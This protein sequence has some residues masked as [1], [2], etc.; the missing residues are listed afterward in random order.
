MPDNHSHCLGPRVMAALT[1]LLC[2][3]SIEQARSACEAAAWG[4]TYSRN[5]C[6]WLVRDGAL[7]ALANFMRSCSSNK[8]QSSILSAIL[9]ILANILSHSE[10][11]LHIEPKELAGLV[12]IVTD[13][14]QL[15]R[16]AAR[17]QQGHGCA[18][19]VPVVS[20]VL[21]ATASAA[22]L[23]VVFDHAAVCRDTEDVFCLAVKVLQRSCARSVV[24]RHISVDRTLVKWKGVYRVL[25]T[26]LQ[27]EGLYLSKLE[28]K[29]GSDASACNATR[30]LIQT[31]E[32][33]Q[34]LKQLIKPLHKHALKRLGDSSST[35]HALTNH[36]GVLAGAFLPLAIASGTGLFRPRC[37]VQLFYCL[38][39]LVYVR[40]FPRLHA[41][42]CL[43]VMTQACHDC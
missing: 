26:R 13:L 22:T 31:S 5:A 21:D 2:S 15:Y 9:T 30:R 39:L 20:H 23:S 19:L 25:Y 37:S 33:L 28:N 29:K 18:N 4:T 16:Y 41:L 42:L 38:L 43:H 24:L 7:A 6:A 10:T 14:L 1:Q 3:N 40:S 35:R 34:I 27:K 32:Q 36:A 17:L 12:P 11:V 8:S